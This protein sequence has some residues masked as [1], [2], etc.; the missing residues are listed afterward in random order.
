MTAAITLTK[1]FKHEARRVYTLLEESE[2]EGNARRLVEWIARRGGSASVRDVQQ[3]CRWLKEPGAAETALTALVSAGRGNWRDVLPTA[4]GGRP[5]RVF[6]L[7]TPSTSTEPEGH[8]Q[9]P[10]VP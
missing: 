9:E 10:E 4:K 7:S 2:D 6:E 8:K 3:G 1:W 5:G